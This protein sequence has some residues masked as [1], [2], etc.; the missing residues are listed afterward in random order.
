[1]NKRYSRKN[2]LK[3]LRKSFKMSGA[4]G[5]VQGKERAEARAK[6][7]Q[8]EK[9]QDKNAPNKN[10]DVK[11]EKPQG[12]KPTGNAHIKIVFVSD[13]KGGEQPLVLEFPKLDNDMTRL[14][15][16]LSSYIDN[17][18]QE[19]VAFKDEADA[20]MNNMKKKEEEKG[21]KE[22]EGPKNNVGREFFKKMRNSL[23]KKDNTPEKAP[24]APAPAP[25]APAP[26]KP[27]EGPVR[28]NSTGSIGGKKTRRKTKSSSKTR[29]N[30]L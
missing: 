11:T 2:R 15:R 4:G 30:L 22:G 28:R 27:A 25:A 10:E 21:E 5:T 14:I 8:N 23:F 7:M 20:I 13:G 1:M 16:Q 29:R 6:N 24:A 19:Q 3:K 12:I 18:K 17:T 26:A 9:A